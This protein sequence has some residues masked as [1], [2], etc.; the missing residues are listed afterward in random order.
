LRVTDKTPVNS[1]YLGLIHSVFPN[2]RVIYVRR[3]P[4]DT[5]LSCHFTQLSAAYSYTTD[6]ADLVHYYRQHRR[7][8]DHWRAVLP[9]GTLLDVPYADLVSDQENWTRKIV[10]FL[11]LEWDARC[12]D[13]HKT[14]RPVMTASFWQA[15]QKLYNTSVGR[16][17]NYK[18]FVGPLL[19]LQDLGP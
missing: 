10:E 4:L 5:C 7:L 9:E 8:V 16:W 2:A 1:D 12:L 13:F 3:D 14:E 15:R 17:R 6:L 19:E 11:G 18:K